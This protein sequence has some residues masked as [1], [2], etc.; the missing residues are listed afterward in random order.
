[1]QDMNEKRRAVLTAA[2]HTIATACRHIYQ[3]DIDAAKAR[4]DVMETVRLKAAMQR[5]WDKWTAALDEDLK[6]LDKPPVIVE[7]QG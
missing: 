2:I 6:A 4:M 3:E 7:V 1:M 5:D